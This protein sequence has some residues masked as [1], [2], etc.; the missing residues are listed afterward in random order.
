PTHPHAQYTTLGLW[1][2]MPDHLHAIIHLHPPHPANKANHPSH[3]I[4]KSL[5]AIVGNYK[6]LASRQ[7]NNLRRTWG[8][9]IWQRGYYERIIRDEIALHNISQ[10]IAN[11]PRRW[12]E[13]RDNLDKLITHM[14]YHPD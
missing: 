4:P 13:K 7:I 2:I 14:N 12:A 10:Y 5:G 8:T 6:S 1:I 3:L 9:S 11:N